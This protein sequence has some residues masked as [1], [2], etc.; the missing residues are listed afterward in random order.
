MRQTAVLIFESGTTCPGNWKRGRKGFLLFDIL[1]N[2]GSRVLSPF[3]KTGAAEG[4][5]RDLFP[6]IIFYVSALQAKASGEVDFF[7]GNKSDFYPAV[8]RCG[9]TVEHCHR[10]PFVGAAGRAWSRG[11]RR[12]AARFH[13]PNT[14]GAKVVLVVLA[15]EGEP[16]ID[17]RQVRHL[18]RRGF[19]RFARC[20]ARES[21]CLSPVA[22]L[23][24]DCGSRE[25]QCFRISARSR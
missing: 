23:A 2:K 14:G 7:T 16:D 10:V 1:F 19:W 13:A 11:R 15:G 3:E 5:L 25:R 6:F 9:N 8:P 12:V 20:R 4:L 17:V 24:G 22:R 18:R 21:S